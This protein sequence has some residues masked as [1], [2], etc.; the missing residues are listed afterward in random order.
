MQFSDLYKMLLGE[1]SAPWPDFH[2]PISYAKKKWEFAK[3]KSRKIP[4]FVSEQFGEVEVF[5]HTE[6]HVNNFFFCVDDNLWGIVEASILR[7]GGLRIKET[8]KCVS[9]GLYMSDVFKDFFLENFLYI[10][11]DSHHTS[12][13]FSLYKRLASDPIIQF[14]VVDENTKEEMTLN[15]PDELD[16]Y[17]GRKKENFIYKIS[18]K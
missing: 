17:Y 14:I 7:D 10:L 18:K 2:S 9:L 1:M 11:S 13:G 6:N 5:L 3:D 16:N 8:V 12:H 4:G 15:S